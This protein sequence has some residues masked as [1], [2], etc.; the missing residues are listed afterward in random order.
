L[1]GVTA[2]DLQKLVGVFRSGPDIFF[3]DPKEAVHNVSQTFPELAVVRKKIGG[4]RLISGS[5]RKS[6]R[7]QRKLLPD[8]PRLVL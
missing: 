7:W 1:N 4:A 3:L 5:V 8:E 6:R 2:S